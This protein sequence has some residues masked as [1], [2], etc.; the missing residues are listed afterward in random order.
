MDIAFV[1]IAIGFVVVCM[2]VMFLAFRLDRLETKLNDIPFAEE[3]D[4]V[5]YYTVGDEESRIAAEKMA[6]CLWKGNQSR[7]IEIRT[8]E[9]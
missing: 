7:V 5:V 9:F 2:I 1:A 8:M 6:A 3:V 4:W